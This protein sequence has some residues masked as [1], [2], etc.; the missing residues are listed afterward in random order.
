MASKRESKSKRKS[1]RSEYAEIRREELRRPE[2]RQRKIV[3][4]KK[5]MARRDAL[6]AAIGPLRNR[7][8][9]E[10]E[11]TVFIWPSLQ[12]DLDS[13]LACLDGLLAKLAAQEA[14]H[15]WGESDLDVLQD[16][17]TLRFN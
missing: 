13:V 3:L 9:K 16:L 8:L 1:L 10:R 11:T 6:L 12:Q 2:T 14:V 7:L 4:G 17:D 5:L 15:L